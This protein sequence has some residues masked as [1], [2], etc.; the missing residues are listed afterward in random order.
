MN[1][2]KNDRLEAVFEYDE[3]INRQTQGKSID[4]FKPVAMIAGANY[5]LRHGAEMSEVKKIFEMYG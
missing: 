5:L 4:H 3:W 2:D 1:S